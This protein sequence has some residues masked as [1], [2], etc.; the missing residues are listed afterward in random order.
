MVEKWDQVLG[1]WDSRDL[2]GPQDPQ[3]LRILWTPGTPRTSGPWD[4]LGPEELRTLGKLPLPF[5]IQNLNIIQLLLICCKK[6]HDDVSHRY[7][8]VVFF[9]KGVEQ[10]FFKTP[11]SSCNLTIFKGCH[12][13]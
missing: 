7:G 13:S 6:Y 11:P 12:Y 2:W 4:P 9:S 10:L 5:K 3:Y 1:P 8:S